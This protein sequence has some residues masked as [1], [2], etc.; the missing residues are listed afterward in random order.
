MSNVFS[1]VSAALIH[2]TGERFSYFLFL[3]VSLCT[4]WPVVVMNVCFCFGCLRRT[5][6]SCKCSLDFPRKKILWTSL[7]IVSLKVTFC[8]WRYSVIG[9]VLSV[10]PIY[11]KYVTLCS[12]K[13][14][15]QNKTKSSVLY[16]LD[17]IYILTLL[18][19]NVNTT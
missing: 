13:T 17:L 16:Y 19:N 1:H 18:F 2:C 15:W 3:I 7:D 9:L 6:F 5:R 8:C 11:V 14:L 12:L 10:M 4:Y